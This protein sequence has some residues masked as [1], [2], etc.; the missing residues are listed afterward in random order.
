MYV[1]K[2]FIFFNILQNKQQKN[3]QRKPTRKTKPENKLYFK[4]EDITLYKTYYS[5]KDIKY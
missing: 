3:F 1:C 4:I 5:D 2:M